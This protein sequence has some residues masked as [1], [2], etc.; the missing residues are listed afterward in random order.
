MRH[1]SKAPQK[2]LQKIRNRNLDEK[3]LFGN[4]HTLYKNIYEYQHS[5]ETAVLDVGSRYEYP[6]DSMEPLFERMINRGD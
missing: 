4:F 2:L 3:F 6:D 1:K 5:K